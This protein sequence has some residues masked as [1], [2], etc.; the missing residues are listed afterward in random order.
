MEKGEGGWILDILCTQIFA[1][2]EDRSLV[3]TRED[4]DNG[5]VGVREVE[6]EDVIRG[7]VTDS[8]GM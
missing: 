1:D 7:I 5:L 6:L 4:S 3:A 8:R 2:G